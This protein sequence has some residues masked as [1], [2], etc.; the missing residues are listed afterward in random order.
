MTR[1]SQRIPRHSAFVQH[2]AFI[3]AALLSAGLAQAFPKP[4]P[5]P[6]TWQ[7]TFQHSVPKRIVVIPRGSDRPQAYWYMTYTI[8]NPDRAEH[9]FVPTFQLL[10]EDGLL[11]RSDGKRYETVNGEVR[12]V[13]RK[14]TLNGKTEEVSEMVPQLVLDTIRRVEKNPAIQS[15][16]QI[17]GPIR[18]GAD[19]AKDGVAIWPEPNPRMGQFSIFV[20]GLSGD[21]VSMKKVGTDYVEMKKDEIPQKTDDVILLRRTLELQYKLL[22]DDKYPGRDALEKISEEW[23]YR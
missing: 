8:G 9:T 3:L 13:K 21:L 7:F 2:S 15:T 20:T 11:I 23:V 14:I 1:P 16:N 22:G 19:E 4:G 17:T 12:E 10:T 5:T 6:H 18:P